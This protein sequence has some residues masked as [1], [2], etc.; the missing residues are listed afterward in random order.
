VTAAALSVDAYVTRISD[1]FNAKI[2]G[3][4]KAE[5]RS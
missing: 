3:D 2:C 5:R 4:G 1:D